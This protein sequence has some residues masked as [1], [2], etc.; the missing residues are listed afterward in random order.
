VIEL[1]EWFEKAAAGS[2]NVKQIPGWQDTQAGD[3]AFSKEVRILPWDLFVGETYRHAM[4]LAK[5]ATEDSAEVY[6]HTASRCGQATAHFETV[7]GAYFRIEPSPLDGSW[8]SADADGRFQLKITGNKVE[9]KENRK[10]GEG[11]MFSRSATFQETK[12]FE[13][14][15]SRTND[16]ATLQNLGFAD[17]GLRQSIIAANPEPSTLTITWDGST[18]SGVWRGLAVRKKPNGKFDGIVQPSS[19]K[20]TI[21]KFRKQ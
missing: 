18:C 10:Q 13:Y 12:S 8:V 20:G 14:S 21:F 7:K 6:S 9:W 11:T 19:S 15:L 1:G 17:A 3:F 5:T 2:A 4:M 16:D